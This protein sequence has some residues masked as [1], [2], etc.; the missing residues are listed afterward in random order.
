MTASLESNFEPCANFVI[1]G[2]EV[3]LS[4]RCRC[5]APICLECFSTL[6]ACLACAT[7][8]LCRRQP[9]STADRRLRCDECLI[10]SCSRCT[11][12]CDRPGCVR[13]VCRQHATRCSNC[14][15]IVCLA[16]RTD[17]KRCRPCTAASKRAKNI[18]ADKQELIFEIDPV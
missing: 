9:T 4:K 5:G 7:C 16:C 13:V 12:K 18:K 10:Y 2:S 11:R 15:T 8:C 17:S 3:A 6:R 14:D 1:C